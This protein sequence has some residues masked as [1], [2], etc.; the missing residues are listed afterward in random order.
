MKLNA[1]NQTH[2]D[3][4]FKGTLLIYQNEKVPGICLWEISMI[5]RKLQGPK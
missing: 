3:E 4:H 2:Q 5:Q 1:L